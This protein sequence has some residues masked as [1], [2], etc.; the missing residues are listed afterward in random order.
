MLALLGL[1]ALMGLAGFLFIDN[2][3]H[4]GGVATGAMLATVLERRGGE[5]HRRA[6]FLE[7]LG[8]LASAVLA[9]GA[10]F[11]MMRLVAA[12]PGS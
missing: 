9:A 2:A 11:T 12:L 4:L 10:L 5:T 8:W 1:T 3:A 6:E 7:A